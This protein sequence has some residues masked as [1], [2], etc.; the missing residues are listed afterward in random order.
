[1]PVYLKKTKSEILSEALTKV[2]NNTPI[3]SVG[4]GSIARSL[5][6]A[7]TA[8]IG[9]LYDALDFNITQTY[10]STATGSALNAIGALYGVE[11][12]KVSG[13]ETVDKSLGAFQFYLEAP[14]SFD[15]VIPRGTNIYTSASSYVGRQHSFSTA[16]EVV[17]PAGRTRA[18]A[19]ITPNFVETVFTAG[20]NTL[21]TH[22]ANTIG[23][24]TIYCTNPRQISPLPAFETDDDYR[25][26]V[27]KEIRV[28]ASGTT[29]SVRFAGLAVANVR[30]VKIRTAPYGM[31]TFEAIVVPESAANTQQTLAAAQAAMDQVKPLGIRM[32]TKTPLSMPVDMVIDVFVPGGRS[33]SI[34]NTVTSR[35][36]VG[37]RRYLQSMLPGQPV[38]FNKLVQVALEANEFVKDVSISSLTINGSPQLNKNYQPQ[39]DEQITSGNIVVNIASS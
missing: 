36:Q 3:T 34:S 22:S 21:T 23:E 14:V 10:L 13:L 39:D 8:E 4:P 32:Y 29:E 28:K 17:I 12:K 20:R 1:M 15:V 2:Q 25:L 33:S 38:I 19:S 35:I 5:I 27:I 37:V 30:D 9:D 24:V 6:E 11:R 18:Y 16:A 7:V 31:G 26:R